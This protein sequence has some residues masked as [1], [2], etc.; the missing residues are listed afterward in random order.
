MPD[1]ELCALVGANW[2]GNPAVASGAVAQSRDGGAT[3]S[4]SSAAYAPITMTAVACPSR[5]ACVAV[6]GDV[7]ARITLVQP[8][9][10]HKHSTTT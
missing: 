1:R 10:A 5:A 8:R 4:L 2:S 7:V 3:F 9:A 6:G